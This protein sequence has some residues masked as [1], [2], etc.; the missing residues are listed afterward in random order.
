[1]GVTLRANDSINLTT[2]VVTR[3]PN[4]TPNGHASLSDRLRAESVKRLTHQNDLRA[5]AHILRTQKAS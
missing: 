1:M 4:L 5:L 2:G 3:A